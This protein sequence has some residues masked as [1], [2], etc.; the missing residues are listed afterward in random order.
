METLKIIQTLSKIGRD[1]SKIVFICCLVG[2][3]GC[4]IGILSL[5]FGGEI[6]KLGGITI[7]SMIEG[8]S[9]MSMP[10]IYTIMAVGMVLC[11]AEAVLSK[12]AE[13]YFKNELADGNPFTLRG[14]KELMRL[15]ILT[16]AIPLGTV[17]VCSIGVSIADNFFPEIEKLSYDGYSSVGL[18]VMMIVSSLLCRYGAK[19][20]DEK[21]ALESIEHEEEG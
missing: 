21:A 20:C 3:G 13:L 4:A 1:F 12:F 2:F 10:T 17:I 5:G 7:H 8:H 19:M 11:V 15:G 14:A 9:S 18:G 16:I 6:F